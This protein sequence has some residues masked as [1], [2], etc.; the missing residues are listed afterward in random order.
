MSVVLIV[1]A[2]SITFADVS[3][4]GTTDQAF[5]LL[6]A[7]A[8]ADALARAR[9]FDTERI[10]RR[11]AE[12]LAQARADVLGVV[13]HDLRNPLN[14]ISSGGRLLLELD[15]ASALRRAG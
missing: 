7:Q 4:I 6:L 15:D 12:T 14:L 13:A 8:A 5:T 1:G 10:A 3:A 2:L 9:S 11:V